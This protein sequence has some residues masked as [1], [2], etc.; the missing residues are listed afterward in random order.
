M[1][2]PY[3][4]PNVPAENNGSPS[5]KSRFNGLIKNMSTFNGPSYLV[6]FSGPDTVRLVSFFRLYYY[7]EW[8]GSF[9]FYSIFSKIT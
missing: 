5:S 8:H 6:L 9:P 7:Q 2:L 4:P 3:S 1:M